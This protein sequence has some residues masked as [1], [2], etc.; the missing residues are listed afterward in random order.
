[1]IPHRL[2][3]LYQRLC[4]RVQRYE[5]AK[6]MPKPYRPRIVVDEAPAT[7]DTRWPMHDYRCHSEREM[8]ALDG[9][10]RGFRS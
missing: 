7:M 4:I 8:R 3:R 10:S 5:R 2:R 6:L 9:K 1:M